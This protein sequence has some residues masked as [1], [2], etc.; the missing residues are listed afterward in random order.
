MKQVCALEF[1]G[2]IGFSLFVNEQGEGDACFLSK[3]AGIEAITK[4]H[5]G[6][7]G[8]A[9]QEGLFVGAQLRDVLAAKNSTVVPQENDHSRLADP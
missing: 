9:I 5:G 7:I 1:H 2:G 3:S 4:S 6:Q 8:S